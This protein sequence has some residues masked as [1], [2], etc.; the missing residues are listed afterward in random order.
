MGAW[1][2]NAES[3]LVGRLLES[4]PGVQIECPLSTC[5]CLLGWSA[6][7]EELAGVEQT[8]GTPSQIADTLN[9][10][11][12]AERETPACSAGSSFFA[13]TH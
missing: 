12:H 11:H 10:K 1:G 9:T 13:A 5:L 8:S 2:A 4:S 6:V 7:C 3:P